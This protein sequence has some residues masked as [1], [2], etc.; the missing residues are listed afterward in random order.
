MAGVRGSSL[1]QQHRPSVFTHYAVVRRLSGK[2]YEITFLLI[3][4]AQAED[5]VDCVYRITSQKTD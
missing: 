2:E 1:I 5:R 3:E 4:Q